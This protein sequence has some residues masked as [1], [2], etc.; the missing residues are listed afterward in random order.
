[1]AG[2]E[3]W[4]EASWSPAVEGRYVLLFVRPATINPDDWGKADC[5]INDGPALPLAGVTTGRTVLI[6]LGRPQAIHKLYLTI[7][8]RNQ[9]GL[10]AVEIH[11]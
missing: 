8:G 11:R 5:R 6:D 1:M 4:F 9:P 3:G 10:A 2:A 7:N